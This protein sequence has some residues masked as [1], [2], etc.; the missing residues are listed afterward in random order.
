MIGREWLAVHGINEKRVVSHG[1]SIGI[2]TLDAHGVRALR[3]DLAGAP[4]DANALQ[5]LA[6]RHTGP[7]G[8]TN[9]AQLPRGAGRRLS[10]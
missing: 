2:E 3:H 10:M 9:T 4:R 6:Q 8:D 5:D 1:F 7:F